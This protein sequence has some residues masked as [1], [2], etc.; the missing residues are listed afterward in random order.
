M[1]IVGMAMTASVFVVGSLLLLPNSNAPTVRDGYVFR[2]EVPRTLALYDDEWRLRTVL[3]RVG[4]A[5]VLPVHPVSR[6]P[7]DFDLSGVDKVML[8]GKQTPR[9]P[10][11]M[12]L[13]WGLDI[14]G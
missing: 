9:K 2:G 13:L 12:G 3:S 7:Q 11:K 5:A 4:D 14:G 6:F 10:C 8:F 1:A